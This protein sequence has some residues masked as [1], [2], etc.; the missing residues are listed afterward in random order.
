[1]M[2]F[3][4]FP[5]PAFSVF[6]LLTAMPANAGVDDGTADA[7]ALVE[8]MAEVVVSSLTV[9]DI[10]RDVRRERFR[11]LIDRYFAAKLIARFVLGKPNWRK[12][13][14]EQ[15]KTY[16]TLFEQMLVERYVDAFANYSGETLDVNSVDARSEHD[17][18]VKTD[19]KQPGAKQ[20]VEVK[21]RVLRREKNGKPIY[22]IVDILVNGLSMSVTQRKEFGS[23]IKNNGDSIGVLLDKMRESIAK[24]QS[25]AN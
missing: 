5:V 9:R 21:W 20:P 11:D 19:L 24:S 7:R 12:A 8:N 2:M 23:I 16:I 3:L 6:L 15:R 13:T 25:Q 10:S 14:K 22:K 4:R 18:L 17:F 1:M